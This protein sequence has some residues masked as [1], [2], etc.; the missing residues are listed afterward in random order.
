ML[1]YNLVHPYMGASWIARTLVCEESGGRAA[2][3]Y[4]VC[5]AGDMPADPDGIR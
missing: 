4:A 3:L 1:Q 5:C 2:V